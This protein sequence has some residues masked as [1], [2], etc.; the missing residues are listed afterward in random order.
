MKKKPEQ[1]K[2]VKIDWKKECELYKE[3][4]EEA[5]AEVEYYE[6][7]TASMNYADA[8]NAKAIEYIHFYMEI[9]HPG[10]NIVASGQDK[11]EVLF[12]RKLLKT[13]QGELSD[14]PTKLIDKS[15]ISLTTPSIFN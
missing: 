2:E 7:K 11:I 14:N 4:W 6:N 10:I 1:V 3:K 9:F 13:L 15:Q 12:I 5:N 8:H